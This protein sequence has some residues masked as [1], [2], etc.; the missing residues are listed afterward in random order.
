MK[1]RNLTP[2]EI[3]L[4]E[5]QGCQADDWMNI[6]VKEAFK[7][8][9]IWHTIFEGQIALGLFGSDSKDEGTSDAG[10]Y[11]ARIINCEIGDHVRIEHVKHLENY[12][13][14]DFC[15]L[16]N[17]GA[18]TVSG[19]T[20][21]GNGTEVEALNEAGG[22]SLIIYDTL[23]AQV[24][25]LMA[26][27]QHEHAMISQLKNLIGLYVTTQ[28]GTKG[29]VGTKASVRHCANI[30]NVNIGECAQLAGAQN[31][32]EGSILSSCEA[33]TKIGNSV[34]AEHFIVQEGSAITAGAILDKCFIGQAVKVGKQFSAENSAFFANSECFHGEACSVFGGPRAY[35]MYYPGPAKNTTPCISA[36]CA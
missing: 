7:P 22:R 33:P 19:E 14:G 3:Y 34:I 17:I 21:F 32:H 16:E 2:D 18:L 11:H 13:I 12:S 20:A 29:V 8:G 10:I 1:L 15:V 25:W 24:A 35:Y 6:V 36:F 27:C 9:Q 5:Q 28:K 26:K 31:L 23:S 30:T 4:L